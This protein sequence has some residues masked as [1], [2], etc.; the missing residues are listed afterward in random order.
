[1]IVVPARQ[2]L[3]LEAVVKA[4]SKN[5][6]SSS[7][8]RHHKHKKHKEHRHKHHK[9]KERE[10][11]NEVISLEESDSDSKCLPYISHTKCRPGSRA[12]AVGG[13]SGG[14]AIF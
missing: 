2:A 14:K 7:R 5:P 12:I 9:Q 11:A 1:L 8:H 6:D 13:G 3:R 10:R 4:R